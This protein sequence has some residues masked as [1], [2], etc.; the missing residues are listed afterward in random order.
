MKRKRILVVDDHP[1]VLAGLAGNLRR[2]AEFEVVLALGSED[3]RQQLDQEG[4]FAVIIADLHMPGGDGEQLLEYVMTTYP[5]MRRIVL[6]GDSVS[7]QAQRVRFL[8]HLFLEK[9]CD[10]SDLQT[11]I[12]STL[13]LAA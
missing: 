4:E 12:R 2:M 5:D 6:T 13:D 9:P 8:C 3:A 10:P 7:E 1:Y 11:A